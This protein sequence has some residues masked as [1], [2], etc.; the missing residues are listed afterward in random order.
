MN[1]NH[2]VSKIN[3]GGKMK[4]KMVFLLLVLFSSTIF[5]QSK[6]DFFTM[7]KGDS[8]AIFLL[9]PL[10]SNEMFT[11]YR[12]TD[13][14]FVN[15]T[16]EE[17]VA[18]ILDENA[19]PVI[20]GDELPFFR[21]AL[22]TK[23]NF[24]IS[25]MLRSNTFR[26][27][28]LSLLNPKAARIGGRWFVDKGLKEGKKYTYKL[29][30]EKNYGEIIDSVEKTVT[31][32]TLIPNPP[33]NL[34]AEALNK[35]IKLS[36]TYP[37]WNGSFNDLG[38][39]YHV[40]RK[41]GR[42]NEF[43]KI[44]KE[45]LL[46]NDAVQPTFTD[47]WLDEG[48]KYTYYV[49]I[50]DPIGNESKPSKKVT[51]KLEDKTPPNIIGLISSRSDTLGIYLTWTMSADLDAKGYDV[52]RSLG[53]SEEYIKISKELIPAEKPFFVDT[54]VYPNKQFFY[55]VTVV[56]TAGNVSPK[57][58][59]HAATYKDV[60]PPAPPTNVTFKDEN[61]LVRL[62][63]QKSK[64][65]DLIGY[66]IHRGERKDITPRLTHIPIKETTYV[67]SGYKDRGFVNGGLIY[68]K[69]AAMD[70]S[71]NLSKMVELT[72]VLPDKDNPKPPTNFT[73]KNYEGRYVEVYCS[74]SPSLD[75]DKYEIFR[76]EENKPDEKSLAIFDKAPVYYRDTSVVK[77]VAYYY[78]SVAI[79]TA[80]N[81]SLPS[82]TD[83]IRFRDY[84]PPRAP[85]NIHAK[86]SNGKVELKW[87]EVVDFDMAGYNIYRSDFPTG[88]FTKLNDSP[89]KETSYTDNG[90]LKKYFYRIKAVDTSGNESKFD[91]TVAPK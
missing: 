76:K 38:M 34:E 28:V 11:V 42:E 79:D 19:I 20:L 35:Q 47:R 3:L 48:I 70:S 74:M 26:G 10:K 88:T 1:G 9:K 59:P 44:E 2:F 40:Y 89:V 71:R 41:T 43:K 12:K 82:K 22:G 77:G 4:N 87:G 61:G 64:A 8:L 52:F 55:A 69:I 23:D 53:L 50:V 84:S 14:G 33:E 62:N 5:A 73:L 56:D 83:T 13:T 7:F 60:I 63:W 29:V 17:P 37:K 24:S 80:G 91:K 85:R 78:Y 25:R 46:R 39:R 15:L 58:N 21:K 68:Y 30:F 36:W 65:K 51:V 81:R 31:A 86:Y 27:N 6:H 54:T 16:G 72:A 90:G 45:I 75:A 67:D 66:V 32:K 57:S 49:T 18:P